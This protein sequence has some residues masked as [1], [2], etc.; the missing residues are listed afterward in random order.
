MN[1]FERCRGRAY[2]P[3]PK[4]KILF[5]IQNAFNHVWKAYFLIHCSLIPTPLKSTYSYL[6]LALNLGL[7]AM[8]IS[9]NCVLLYCIELGVSVC[10]DRTGSNDLVRLRER[11]AGGGIPTRARPQHHAW[12]HHVK[13]WLGGKR[14]RLS[15]PKMLLGGGGVTLE[16]SGSAGSSC[17]LW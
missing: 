3:L 7:F 6:F 1:Q 2:R 4:N 16:T 9:V 14:R 13:Q 5:C 15:T 11:A 8:C 10:N 17:E 12:H